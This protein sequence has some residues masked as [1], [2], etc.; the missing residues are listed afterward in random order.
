MPDLPQPPIQWI[1]TCW[2]AL[3]RD[4]TAEHI[5]GQSR[6][7]GTPKSGT[8]MWRQAIFNAAR[9]DSNN[10]ISSAKNSGASTTEIT[11]DGAQSTI[12]EKSDA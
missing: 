6:L 9:S 4:R 8:G 5:S 3:N 12:L 10:L 7:V 2:P 1:R 11:K